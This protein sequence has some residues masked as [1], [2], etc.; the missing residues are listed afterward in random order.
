MYSRND[1]LARYGALYYTGGGYP[2]SETGTIYASE[3]RGGYID[4]ERTH[5]VLINPRS[6]RKIDL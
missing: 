5:P 1:A 6:M 3:E 2:L 4:S